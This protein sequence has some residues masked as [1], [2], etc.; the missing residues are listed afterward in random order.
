MNSHEHNLNDAP[1]AAKAGGV[2]L[3]P[4]ISP[5]P[6]RR[7][8]GAAILRAV[9]LVILLAALVVA[10]LWAARRCG[11]CDTLRKWR[12]ECP[13]S[14]LGGDADGGKSLPESSGTTAKGVAADTMAT[15]GSSSAASKIEMEP[16]ADG[17]GD[18][19][20]GLG[21][22]GAKEG[23]A[24]PAVTAMAVERKAKSL[25]SVGESSRDAIAAYLFP[26]GDEVFSWFRVVRGSDYVRNNAA[27]RDA[28]ANTRF[29]YDESNEAIDAFAG[30]DDESGGN[31]ANLVVPGGLVRLSRVIG[32]VMASGSTAAADAMSRFEPLTMKIARSGGRTSAAAAMEM[33]AECGVS[34]DRFLDEAFVR[35]ARAISNGIGLSVTAHAMG[36]IALGHIRRTF[37]MTSE[38]AKSREEEADSFALAVLGEGNVRASGVV[39]RQMFVGNVYLMAALA[40]RDEL[41]VASVARKRRATSSDE[42]AAIRAQITIERAHPYAGERLADQLA[43]N[44]SLF[45]QYG[46]DPAE[47]ASIIRSLET[48]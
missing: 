11:L 34:P 27:Y 19:L 1:S 48:R 4:P 23:T 40:A 45:R 6:H 31:G 9:L 44:E 20:A 24:Q 7:G 15:N 12:R 26:S 25:A 2:R 17:I 16:V 38:K 43:N 35:E 5:S 8:P 21:E 32:A 42:I 41:D 30:R 29:N 46:I 13:A 22:D 10:A 28:A 18:F 33:L 36:H 14:A 37:G 3:P 39:S 47:L